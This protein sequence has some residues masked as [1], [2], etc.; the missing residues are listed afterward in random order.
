MLSKGIRDEE[1][2]R[3]NRM[4]THLLE[5]KFVSDSWLLEQKPKVDATLK[6]IIDLE[7]IEILKTS[8]EELLDIL[9]SKNFQED[10]YESFGDL[11]LNISDME[12]QH[13]HNLAEKSL[14]IYQFAQKQSNTFSIS[15]NQKIQETKGPL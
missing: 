5:M 7:I 1:N 3:I 14:A 9:K 12:P 13:Q 6:E 2:E 15:L 4:I 10:H 8:S 11:L